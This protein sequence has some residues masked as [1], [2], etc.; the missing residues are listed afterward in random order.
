MIGLI[1]YERAYANWE[2]GGALAAVRLAGLTLVHRQL[3][4][5]ARRGCRRLVVWFPEEL[6]GTPGLSPPPDLPAEYVFAPISAL[7]VRERVAELAGESGLP[8]VLMRGDYVLQE[9]AVKGV[10][11]R[12]PGAAGVAQEDGQRVVLVH[13]DGPGLAALPA[14]AD[15]APAEGV[16][17]RLA[18]G[19]S[20]ARIEISGSGRTND[21]KP[22]GTYCF[23]LQHATDLAGAARRMLAATQKGGGDLLGRYLHPV[24]EDTMV[25]WLLPTPVT[26]NQITVLNILVAACA[27][28]LYARSWF[29]LGVLVTIPVGILDGVDGKLARIKLLF[30]RLGT[31]L[32]GIFI[33]KLAQTAWV[34]AIG[35]GLYRLDHQ[36]LWLWLVVGFLCTDNLIRAVDGLYTLRFKEEQMIHF[37][38]FRTIRAGRNTY[39]L[40]LMV[41]ALFNSPAGALWA[42]VGW[43]A[44]TVLVRAVHLLGSLVSRRAEAR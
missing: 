31:I 29:V 1:L 39:V 10:L 21:A 26:P 5:L 23:R 27:T 9:D 38:R 16:L 33:D 7:R 2:G 30:S 18:G 11:D 41:A 3:K 25:R 43:G 35:W 4:L 20:L 17:D 37:P 6:Q 24:P 44:V 8:V 15:D 19:T 12:G 22:T 14:D 32:D 40:I 42:L 13:L 36:P 28:V 34:A